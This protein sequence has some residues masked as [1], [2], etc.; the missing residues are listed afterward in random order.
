MNQLPLR[1]IA[2]LLSIGTNVLAQPGD[3]HIVVGTS[4]A[5]GPGADVPAAPAAT[6][7]A[8]AATAPAQVA[9]T[10][11][12][13]VAAPAP[14]TLGASVINA[15]QCVL[16]EAIGPMG[17]GTG[18]VATGSR[19]L[20]GTKTR[21]KIELPRAAA[22]GP[23]GAAWKNCSDAF[24][25]QGVLAVRVTTT[26]V[27][28]S[29][30][31]DQKD[32]FFNHDDA[33][34]GAASEFSSTLFAAESNLRVRVWAFMLTA[35]TA[36]TQEISRRYERVDPVFDNVY[37]VRDYSF[38]NA[39]GYRATFPVLWR[40]KQ[41]DTNEK[42]AAG[43]SAALLIY[44]ARWFSA[45]TV[46]RSFAVE[47][48]YGAVAATFSPKAA[49]S[50]TFLGVGLSYGGVLGAGFAYDLNASKSFGMYFNLT[51]FSEGGMFGLSK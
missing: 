20:V 16:L 12:P 6:A 13:V 31:I 8:A 9:A 15:R 24:G 37:E 43:A 44:P 21:L 7:P 35:E 34:A 36:T 40:P 45:S 50:F 3:Q 48:Q 47:G 19:I 41:G 26:N 5:I 30:E 4:P 49:R 2:I 42:Y 29:E 22:A 18:Q 27:S 17:Q 32:F 1:S 25:A 38:T 10:T 23:L 39:F 51:L 28:D 33:E 14:A 11:T 46:A